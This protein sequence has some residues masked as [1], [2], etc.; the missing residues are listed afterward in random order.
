MEIDA[1]LQ[2]NGLVVTASDRAARALVAAFDRARQ[3][4]GLTAWPTPR[5]LDWNRFAREA[6]DERGNDARLL[7][8]RAQEQA[9][10]VGIAG[11]DRSLATLLEAPRHRLAELAMEAHE[12]LCSQ[13]PQFLRPSARIGWQQDAGAFSSWLAAF[14]ENCRSGNL[15]SPSR[16]P[17]ELI[18]LGRVARGNQE[19]T[20]HRSSFSRRR[21]RPG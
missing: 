2:K 11:E 21:R 20:G 19:R 15:L 16:L 17:L 3:T 12:L 1:W 7:L 14:D 5:I 6:W 13:A 4:E 18:R 10:W 9:L 8:N